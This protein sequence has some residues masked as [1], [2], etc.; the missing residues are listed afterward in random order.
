MINTAPGSPGFPDS[1]HF[2]LAVLIQEPAEVY[3]AKAKDY[4]SS[5]ALADFRRCPVLF[6]KKK[7]GLI[8]DKDSPAYLLG[9]AAHTLI[10][11]GRDAFEAG[12]AFGG[13]INPQTGKPYG[14]NTKAFAEWLAIQGKPA[15]SD[16]Q[17][18]QVEQMAAG[19]QQHDA[20]TDLLSLGQ[21]EGVVRIE[22]RGLLCQIR[23]DWLNP[24]QGI[25]DLKT[26]DDLTWFEADARR[27]EYV[28]Q[29][30]FYRAVLAQAVGGLVTVHIVAVE[31]K[32]PFRCGVWRVG[33]DVLA[34]AQE[35]NEQAIDR[36]LGC[37]ATDVWP[38]GYEDIRTFDHL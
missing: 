38:T 21:A 36:L 35:D 25:V 17:L 6:H 16:D 33:Q 15:L 13:P 9:R 24:E 14:V 28:H 18:A 30:A 29:L 23:I 31:K 32:E 20:A 22:Y 10:L 11:E 34:I 27:F 37:Y 4:L 7:Q 8:P 1:A 3:H 12:Y 5:H 2:D 26:C 19:V